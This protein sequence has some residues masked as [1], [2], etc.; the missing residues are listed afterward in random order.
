M[1]VY[2]CVVPAG[3]LNP[4]LRAALAKELTSIH[5]EITGASPEFV[6][7]VF[8]ELPEGTT[9]LNG[10]PSTM[11]NVSGYIRAGR[12]REVREQLLARI[13]STWITLTGI[14]AEHLKITL[15]D[16]PANWIMQ[17]GS[18]MPEIGQDQDWLN[19]R[20]RSR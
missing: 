10:A 20:G 1:P 8:L 18:M 2:Q 7:V 5:C 9:F 4:V 14:P 6:Q 16:V 19:Q 12:S 13:N 11:M 15:F 17:D 3:S